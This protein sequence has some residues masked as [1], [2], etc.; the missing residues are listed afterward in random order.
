M[1]TLKT[2][3]NFFFAGLTAATVLSAANT[4]DA[5]GAAGLWYDH[6]GRSAIQVSKCGSGLC[7]RI[8]WLKKAAHKSVCGT[9]I[10]GGGKRVGNSYDTGWIY[11]PERR[12]KY[13]VE[14]TP[15]G[16]SLKVM[17]YAGSKMLSRTMIWKRAP[18]NLKRCA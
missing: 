16:N 12:K 15:Q 13:S 11:S 9:R 5:A 8:V 14:I 18:S 2:L 10:I 4:A 6:T 17:G 7:G 1:N 3:K